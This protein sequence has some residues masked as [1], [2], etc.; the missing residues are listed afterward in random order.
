MRRVVLVTL[1]VMFALLPGFALEQRGGGR[2][3]GGGV[4]IGRGGAGGVVG[5]RFGGRGFSHHYGLTTPGYGFWG[6]NLWGSNYGG[7][8]GYGGLYDGYWGSAYGPLWYGEPFGYEQSDAE[9][10]NAPAPPP[11]VVVAP[12]QGQPPVA[13]EVPP[14]EP[15]IIEIPGGVRKAPAD[16]LPPAI[17]LL[18]NGERLE[19]R[20]Y[21]LTADYLYV[22][23]DRQRRTIPLGMLDLGATIAANR[24]RGIDLSI[25]ADHHEISLGF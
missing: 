20:R 10:L 7:L 17:F 4:G 19:A 6:R 9:W 16:P 11:P 1:L 13:R 5:G 15:Q 14:V 24:Q 18:A 23:V 21:M 3:G 25:P 8:Y 12:P 22:T 2:G